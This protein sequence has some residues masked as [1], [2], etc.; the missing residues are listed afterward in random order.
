MRLD[1]Y[2]VG[3]SLAGLLVA[4]PATSPA[5]DEFPGG[6]D[7]MS[8]AVEEGTAEFPIEEGMVEFPIDQSAQSENQ[9]NQPFDIAE[10]DQCLVESRLD[11]ATGEI[12]DVYGLCSDDAVSGNLDLS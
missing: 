12:I 5:N 3:F 10:V 1:K 11:P 2:F 8:S 9:V 7:P 6:T 4:N